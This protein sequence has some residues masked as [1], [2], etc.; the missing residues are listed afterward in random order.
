MRIRL[1]PAWGLGLLLAWTVIVGWRLVWD[2]PP[3]GKPLEVF[4]AENIDVIK[5]THHLPRVKPGVILQEFHQPPL[6]YGIVTL[7]SLSDP[8]L[9]DRPERLLSNPYYLATTIGNRSPY[10]PIGQAENTVYIGRLVGLAALLIAVLATYAQ[11][12]LL[13]G[14]G[15]A[16]FAAGLLALHPQGVFIATSLS[17]DGVALGAAAIIFW[18]LVRLL[19]TD[20]TPRRALVLGLLIGG[21]ILCKPHLLLTTA[22]LPVLVWR[23]RKRTWRQWIFYGALIA[24]GILLVSGPWMLHNYRLYHDPLALEPVLPK[25]VQH[26]SPFHY[27]LDPLPDFWKSFWLDFSPGLAGYAPNRLYIAVGIVIALV[28]IGLIVV[29]IRHPHR[30]VPV[31]MHGFFVLLVL[32]ASL[33]QK[34]QMYAHGNLESPVAEGRHAFIMLPSLMIL[35]MLAAQAIPARRV[36][37]GLAAILVVLGVGVMLWAVGPHL[38]TVYGLRPLD[39]AA[40]LPPPQEPVE[41]T[42]HMRLVGFRHSAGHLQGQPGRWVDLEWTT[43]TP[44]DQNWSVSVQALGWNQQGSLDKLA[45][46]DSYPGG[47][48]WPTRRWWPGTVI[49]DRYFVPDRSGSLLGVFV[50]NLA[51]GESVPTISGNLAL[52]PVS[53][54]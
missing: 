13:V 25:G 52:F 10:L 41:F 35:I 1:R 21:G 44:L 45:Q 51:T 22:L 16:L 34:M 12:R 9:E 42:N 31:L 43:D 46:Q 23:Y 30:R 28:G 32:A 49:R 39:A 26:G 38:D 24:G 8:P 4:H 40:H 14:T 47:G 7:L 50:Y 33:W 48:L 18:W 15:W 11:A 54:P 36:R 29:L 5:T 37:I 17:N 19:H 2:V 3:Y 6:Y 27:L 20:L 53:G